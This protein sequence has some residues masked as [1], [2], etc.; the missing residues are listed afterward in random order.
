MLAVVAPLAAVG[1]ST[2]TFFIITKAVASFIK[3][4]VTSP[5]TVGVFLE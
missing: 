4:C 5:H 2:D 3:V 1:G